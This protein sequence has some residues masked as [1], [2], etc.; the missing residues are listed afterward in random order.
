VTLD[1]YVPNKKGT[2]EP[3]P[4]RPESGPFFTGGGRIL[5]YK[6]AVDPRT[7]KE[8]RILEPPYPEEKV[9]TEIDWVRAEG[10]TKQVRTDPPL[11]EDHCKESPLWFQPW[12]QAFLANLNAGLG[13]TPVSTPPGGGGGGTP[14]PPVEGGER[15]SEHMT[16]SPVGGVSGMAP[17]G[18]GYPGMGGGNPGSPPE[19]TDI[20]ILETVTHLVERGFAGSGWTHGE[21]RR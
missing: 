18:A 10:N 6:D 14:R 1:L 20:S 17:V 8:T 7:G 15:R 3:A 13:R 16:K 9:D 12:L 21:E 11:V 19:S 5:K 4:W 2:N